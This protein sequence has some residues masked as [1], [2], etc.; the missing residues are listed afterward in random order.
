MKKPLFSHASFLLSVY[1]IEQ[2]EQLPQRMGKKYP[3]IAFIGRSNVGKSSLINHLTQ[4]KNL[5]KV[6]SLPGKTQCLNFFT[7]DDFFHLVD[8]PGYGYAKAALKEVEKWSSLIENYLHSKEPISLLLHLLDAKLPPSK[9]DLQFFS[10]AMHYQLPY[11]C[12]TTKIDKIK[13][14]LLPKNLQIIQKSFGE[15]SQTK[16]EMINYS[17]H[18]PLSRKALISKIREYF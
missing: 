12:V 15:I 14:S 2:L 7:I 18:D 5:A 10:W 11:L 16:I 1:E 8:L 3:Q 17:I 4:K 9:E 6:S 13:P